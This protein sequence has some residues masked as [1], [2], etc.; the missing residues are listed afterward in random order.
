M[1]V[2]GRTLLL[3]AAYYVSGRLGML[4]AI[5]PGYATAMWPPSGIALAGLLLFGIRYWPGVLL[6]SFTVNLFVAFDS[7]DSVS[8]LRSGA[9]AATIACGAA[10]QAVAGAWLVRR[11]I[12]LPNPLERV[13][14][15]ALLL[16]L[17]G[18]VACL[19]A[20][21]AGAS[22]L[23]L[24]GIVPLSSA[25]F[26]WL[27]WWVGDIIGVLVFTP[28]LLLLS[29]RQ[30]V[31]S[32]ARKIGVGATLLL[33]FALVVAMFFVA[34][35]QERERQRL[36]LR[37]QAQAAV[38]SLETRLA[39]Y[40]TILHDTRALFLASERVTRDEF[41]VFTAH[42]ADRHPGLAALSWSELIA[43]GAR[44]G[45]EERMRAEGYP[46]FS[47]REGDPQGLL[48]A[49]PAHN[50]YLPVTY[51]EPY[52]ERVH[53]FDNLAQS[54]RRRAILIAR[55]R[56]EPVATGRLTLVQA[57]RDTWGV[58]VYAPIYRPGAPLDTLQQRRQALRG[59]VAAALYLPRVLGGQSAEHPGAALDVAILDD[60]APVA[61]ELLYESRPRAAQRLLELS[62]EDTPLWREQ[63]IVAGR[64]WTVLMAPSAAAAVP[65]N[66]TVW[67]VLTGGLLFTGLF[68]VFAL[69]VSAQSDVVTRQVAERT[70]ALRRSRQQ[71]QQ[72]VDGASDAICTLD[73]EGYVTDW[74]AAAE[75]ITG[76]APA[77]ILGRHC[78]VFMPEG[79]PAD[80]TLDDVRQLGHR[81]RGGWAAHKDGHRIWID[82]SVSVLQDGNRQYGFSVIARDQT[83]SRQ[84]AEEISASFREAS[85]LKAMLALATE[86]GRIG[87]WRRD[88]VSGR[89]FFDMQVRRLFGFGAAD[90][91]V[92]W[93]DFIER[94][95]PEDREIFFT[96]VEPNLASGAECRWQSWIVL[97]GGELRYLMAAAKGE[98]DAA[99]RLLAVVGATW[100][101]TELQLARLAAEQAARAKTEFLANMS[102]EIR[103]PMNGILGLTS[104]VLESDLT[105]EQRGALTQVK[106][107]GMALL[108]LV[109]DILDL[110]KMGS[111]KLELAPMAFDL[112]ATVQSSLQGF[113][114]TARAKGVQL[115]VHVSDRLP[116]VIICDPY[117]LM[118]IINNL[119]SN[120]IK[121]T[122]AGSVVVTLGGDPRQSS[123]A[124]DTC[125]LRIGV[126]DT[127]IG[128]PADAQGRL[129]DTFTQADSSTTRRF[130][131]SGLG[132]SIC[133][134]LAERMGGRIWLE[135]EEGAGSTF[136]VTVAVGIGDPAQI[137]E[138]AIAA[139]ASAPATAPLAAGQG[140]RVL[141]AEDHP[142]NQE[143]ALA[144]LRRRG[145]RV[146][147]APNGRI[148]VERY[149]QQPFDVVLMDVQMPEMDGIEATARIR[150]LEKSSGR[151]IR[152][153]A[154]TA[155]ALAGDR[156]RLLAAG[157]DDYL[158]KPFFPEQLLDV[159]EQRATPAAAA[160]PGP[161]VECFNRDEALKRAMNQLPLL[162]RLATVF[163]DELPKMR[164]AV[165]AAVAANDAEALYREAHRLKGSAASIAAPACTAIA[166]ELEQI[167][168]TGAI[169]DVAAQLDLMDREVQRLHAA[170]AELIAETP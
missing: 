140:L 51:I 126:R 95:H 3:A 43:A 35:D 123:Q 97:P 40:L 72:L 122:H 98:F 29:N 24:T 94:I 166:R 22:T 79:E 103:T 1:T 139:P 96:E 14:D 70:D 82:V 146:E 115:L 17:G 60:A 128:I 165:H 23:V 92:E 102:H 120:A 154:L 121:F 50:E 150:E 80:R 148:A 169:G 69:M 28:I 157:M 86:A 55:D 77:E 75:S 59:I 9:I 2:I 53:G 13:R 158:A 124:G 134:Q 76:Y 162:Q 117:R 4:L 118:Q 100:D 30:G 18:P 155:H 91:D 39:S 65:V 160:A 143:L 63:V 5:P 19:V 52:A 149:R 125:E 147:L 163:L 84:Q 90:S 141:L 27:T 101:V 56:N 161:D 21:T 168:R 58:L 15:I 36:A 145:H 119:V 26:T 144:V 138:P 93:A 135:S 167:G 68:G 142:T 88:L 111:G 107:S 131:G 34:R 6:G 73:R 81:S 12:V 112:R 87:V 85:E 11:A 105:P 133:R 152:I 108:M 41:Q 136:H 89:D 62:G 25:V 110:S 137:V 114:A 159:V 49:A 64:S 54:D 156:E 67:T 129:F 127:G 113:A 164:D 57:S 47:I 8:M 83:R 45:Y 10:L 104:L 74:N 32:R 170:I 71:L 46:G 7:S 31:I 61:S 37:S 66:W 130:G 116:P 20:A 99:G 153:V 132:L 78:S 42:A 151:H 33:V 38:A 106:E 48:T 16:V 44:A 109:N